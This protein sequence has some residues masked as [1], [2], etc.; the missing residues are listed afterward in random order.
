MSF[1]SLDSIGKTNLMMDLISQRQ[2]ALGSN[3]ANVDTPGYVRRDIDFSQYPNL[4]VL[5]IDE[6]CKCTKACINS[7]SRCRNLERLVINGQEIA[8]PIQ[9]SKKRLNFLSRLKKKIR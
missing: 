5:E 4:R 8:L 2:R 1:T 6:K 3:V 9:A 7:I